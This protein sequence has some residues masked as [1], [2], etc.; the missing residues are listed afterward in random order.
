MNSTIESLIAEIAERYGSIR[1]LSEWRSI[2]SL[3]SMDKANELLDAREKILDEISKIRD[4][5]AKE[6]PETSE[7]H[8]QS[9]MIVEEEIGKI[10]SADR[11]FLE[12]LKERM[13]FIRKEI[14]SRSIFRQRAL[15]G[16][17]RQKMAF[18]LR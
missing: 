8:S 7:K 15:P 13:D 1:V 6:H 5:I 18:A 17:L 4:K 16:Y 14:Q 11:F 10:E 9:Y 2:S 3:D 12:K